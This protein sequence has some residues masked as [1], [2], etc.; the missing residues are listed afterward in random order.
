VISPPPVIDRP[1][2]RI[3]LAMMLT[4][5][6]TVLV[7]NQAPM[8]GQID[9]RMRDPQPGD[10]VVEVSLGFW[11]LHCDPELKDSH[12]DGQFI[13]YLRHDTEQV[14]FTEDPEDGSYTEN[15]LVCMNPDGTEFRWSN[16]ML[17]VVPTE[18]NF[19]IL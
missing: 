9:R 12:W 5:Q 16:A 6:S 10:L 19:S 11:L 17:A 14:Q 1:T 8:V 7:G 2:K 3:M 13:T 4:L 15:F 18:Y